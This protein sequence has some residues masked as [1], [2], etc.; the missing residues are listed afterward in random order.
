MFFIALVK[1]W[2]YTALL[3]GSSVFGSD[4]DFVVIWYHCNKL[5][6]ASLRNGI[7]FPSNWDDNKE[8]SFAAEMLGVSSQ[9]WIPEH[10]GIHSQIFL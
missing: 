8:I 5:E 7:T 6:I 4:R 1:Q 9:Y 10:I 3:F 2:A